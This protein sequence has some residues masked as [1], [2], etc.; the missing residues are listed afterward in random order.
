MKKKI[1]KILLCLS[2]IIVIPLYVV[3]S[4]VIIIIGEDD[5]G[6]IINTPPS[7]DAGL[8]QNIT[9]SIDDV[10][11]T[12]SYI[13]TFPDFFSQPWV[14]AALLVFAMV[15]TACISGYLIAYRRVLKYPRPV[16]KVRKFRRTLNRSK[17]PAV[18]IMSKDV[19]FN[20]AY[21]HELTETSKS[22]K[23]KT[24]EMKEPKVTDKGAID[25]QT[26]KTMEK[27]IDSE[28]LITKSLEKKQELDSLVE[29]LPEK[30]DT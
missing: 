20:L 3:Y 25:K 9:V 7:V 2:L 12:I 24:S 27:K 11:L 4:D 5:P 15:A 30:P 28:E 21:N 16:R 10:Y 14:F 22:L 23:L 19:A 18:A 26:E 6:I 8:D 17:T 13:E 1:L 29:K